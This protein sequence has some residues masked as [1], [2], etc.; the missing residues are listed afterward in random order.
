M[1]AIHNIDMDMKSNMNISIIGGTGLIGRALAEELVRS[2]DDVTVLSRDPGRAK[3]IPRGASVGEW[4]T[5]DP[6]R[7]VE[8]IEKSDAVIN[9]A[10]AS[11]MKRWSKS[12]KRKIRQSRVETGKLITESISQAKKKPSVLIQASAVGYYGSRGNE[13][14]TEG[15]VPGEG[16]LAGVAVEWEDSTAPVEKMGVRRVVVRTGVVLSRK[17]GAL[18]MTALP[19]RFFFGGPLGSGRQWMPWIHLDDVARAIGFLIKNKDAGGVFNITSPQPVTNR[20]F[21]RALGRALH[22]PAVFRVPAFLI[23]LLLGEM[24]TVVLEGQKAM[25]AKIIDL[26]FRHRFPDIESALKDLLK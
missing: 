6:N 26:G 8:I 24:S 23:R 2:G 4:N 11:I 1:L 21:S 10:G 17:V 16:F 22:R 18:P 3:S 5:Y 25:P 15:S 9:L 13:E 14:I 20:E 19:F 7:N 12:N